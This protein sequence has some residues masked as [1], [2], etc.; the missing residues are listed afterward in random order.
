MS[1][2]NGISGLFGI[3]LSTIPPPPERR[4]GP[5]IEQRYK[6]L[7]GGGNFPDLSAFIFG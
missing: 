1:S 7:R 5:E 6:K 2:K 4:P 3:L